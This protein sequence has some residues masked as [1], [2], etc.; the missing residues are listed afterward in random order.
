MKADDELRRAI[1]L[2]QAGELKTAVHMLERLAEDAELDDKGRAAAYVWLAESRDN[3]EF[4]RRCLERA[5]RF[6]P[7]NEQILQGLSQLRA[8]PR[9]PV[10]RR[11]AAKTHELEYAPEVVAIKGGINGMASGAFLNASGLVATTSYAVGSATTVSV[12]MED[13]RNVEGPVVS[14]FPLFDLALIATPFRLARKPALA[15]RAPAGHGVSFVAWSGNGTRLRAELAPLDHG[16]ARHWLRTNLPLKGLPD[17]G[18]N[19]LRDE[20]GQLLGILT[21]NADAAG[22]A[23]GISASHIVAMVERHQRERQLQPDADYCAQCGGL[24]RA[25]QFGGQSCETCG[26]TLAIDIARENTAAQPDKLRQL[27]G[28]YRHAPCPHCDARAGRYQGRCL[29]CGRGAATGN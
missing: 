25:R 26:A 13:L 16:G 6:E 5:L 21:R 3:H 23:L 1:R 7:E 29:R 17:A 19:P 24:T 11:D 18:G 15:G 28:E 27:T 2:I 12:S 22:N 8:A 9:P 20:T 14:R 4:K 10:M